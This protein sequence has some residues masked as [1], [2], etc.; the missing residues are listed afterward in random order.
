MRD[1]DDNF[2]RCARRM[3]NKVITNCGPMQNISV[4]WYLII[5][6]WWLQ[7][8]CNPPPPF[9]QEGGF[10]DFLNSPEK[11]RV[12]NFSHKKGEV[13]K[14]GR[15]SK[16]GGISYVSSSIMFL[17]VFFFFCSLTSFLSIF[18]FHRRDLVL[19]NLISK[20][21]TSVHFWKTKTLQTC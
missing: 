5:T 12:L 2:F 21:V 6:A 13:G 19:L 17:C 20:Y 3:L 10:Y 9:S 15:Y 1:Y 18:V 8:S 7:H 11:K 14:I 16:K 4:C